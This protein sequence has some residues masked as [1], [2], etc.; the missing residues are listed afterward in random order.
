MPLLLLSALKIADILT[1]NTAAIRSYTHWPYDK[2]VQE[3]IT[4]APPTLTDKVQHQPQQKDSKNKLLLLSV[5][6]TK[7]SESNPQEAS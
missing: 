5:S 6:T 7:T 2:N 4:L 1:A 3:Q